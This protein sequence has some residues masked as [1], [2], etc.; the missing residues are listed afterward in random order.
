[1]STREQWGKGIAVFAAA[2]LG[3]LLLL[4]LGPTDRLAPA[5]RFFGGLL[6][7]GVSAL[8]LWAF[9]PLT[10]PKEELPATFVPFRPPLLVEAWMRDKRFASWWLAPRLALG[11]LWLHAGWDKLNN[12]A[13]HD[14]SAILGYWQ[15]AVTVPPGG[16]P[17]VAFDWYADFLKYMIDNGWNAWFQ[18]VITWG[19]ILVGVGLILGALTAIAAFFGML[20][21]LT[22]LLAG[23]TSTNPIMLLIALSLILGWAVCGWYGLDRF[24]FPLL[25]YRGWLVEHV[26]LPRPPQSTPA[27]A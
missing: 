10:R 8:L 25:S 23:T 7:W 3:F 16:R 13:W 4:S 6:M 17:V 22:F 15:R 27:P 12:P 26:H 20:M 14:G 24:I 2:M 1:M 19:E 21:N 5:A 18:Y 11:Y 9:Y